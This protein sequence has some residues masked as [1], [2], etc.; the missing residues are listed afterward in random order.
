MQKKK[1]DLTTDIVEVGSVESAATVNDATF[2]E[3]MRL[4]PLT[5]MLGIQVEE[6]VRA[7]YKIWCARHRMKMNEAF[8]KGFAL[9]KEKYNER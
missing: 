7:D 8:L 4:E 3:P 2:S 9:L 5:V 6:Q 1:F